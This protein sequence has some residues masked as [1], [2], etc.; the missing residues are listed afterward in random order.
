MTENDVFRWATDC[1]DSISL[2][3]TIASIGRLAHEDTSLLK[4]LRQILRFLK[5]SQA[6]ISSFSASF[7]LEVVSLHLFWFSSTRTLELFAVVGLSKTNCTERTIWMHKHALT[8]CCKRTSTHAST[9]AV[10]N[11]VG[12]FFHVHPLQLWR[13][14]HSISRVLCGLKIPP[15][16]R[17]CEHA[18]EQLLL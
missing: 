5:S 2:I 4:F 9:I 8:R 18:T 14:V 3:H 17:C 11:S 12:C 13:K 7:F 1:A 16:T 6:S 15:K 10:A